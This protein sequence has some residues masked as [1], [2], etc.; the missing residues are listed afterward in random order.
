M[1]VLNN[2]YLFTVT[3]ATP[4]NG[5]ADYLDKGVDRDGRMDGLPF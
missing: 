3:D 5:I 1:F 4:N 2:E